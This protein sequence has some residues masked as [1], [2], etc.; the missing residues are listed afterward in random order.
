MADKPKDQQ[1]EP[2]AA[3]PE[4]TADTTHTHTVD[5]CDVQIMPVVVHGQEHAADCPNPAECEAT[6]KRP[7]ELWALYEQISTL[8]HD[9]QLSLE[10]GLLVVSTVVL[11]SSYRNGQPQAVQQRFL[12]IFGALADTYEVAVAGA[13]AGK[14]HAEI[15]RAVQAIADQTNAQY[16]AAHAA[17]KKP[18]RH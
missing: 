7:K 12:N 4:A 14:S 18:T 1:P 15:T 2:G 5:P 8:F 6:S 16:A 11:K 9:N 13:K 3:V 17:G 10:E